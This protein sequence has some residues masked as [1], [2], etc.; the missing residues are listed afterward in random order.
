MRLFELILFFARCR[1]WVELCLINTD[2]DMFSSFFFRS[3]DATANMSIDIGPTNTDSVA[4]QCNIG[5]FV[6]SFLK[7]SHEVVCLIFIRQLG[8]WLV[9][10][11]LRFWWQRLLILIHAGRDWLLIAD[12]SDFDSCWQS[13]TAAAG[14]FARWV[15]PI[16]QVHSHTPHS[17]TVLGIIL[18]LVL[19]WAFH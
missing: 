14:Q 18:K 4:Q 17:C 12:N 3:Y 9:G 5:L 2:I 13:W 8:V 16:E 10:N 1:C 19:F 11:I 15:I 6:K 7:V